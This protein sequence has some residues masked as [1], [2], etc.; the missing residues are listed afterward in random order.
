MAHD[1]CVRAGAWQAHRSPCVCV[2]APRKVEV[3]NICS[4]AQAVVFTYIASTACE[5][6]SYSGLGKYSRICVCHTASYSSGR[7]VHRQSSECRASRRNSRDQRFRFTDSPSNMQLIQGSNAPSCQSAQ[8]Q[9]RV[10]MSVPAEWVPPAPQRGARA[11]DRL[12][13]AIWT[14]VVLLVPR[15]MVGLNAGQVFWA[16]P[17]RTAPSLACVALTDTTDCIAGPKH[18]SHQACRQPTNTT[19]AMR[20]QFRDV[21]L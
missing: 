16:C 20:P 18:N 8:R 15:G 1:I 11:R 3:K 6:D 9:A 19:F 10:K 2:Y 17:H 21:A 14:A 13:V 12:R 7:V 4:S 5:F